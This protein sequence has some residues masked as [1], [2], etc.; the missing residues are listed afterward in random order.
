MVIVTCV[1][2]ED[3]FGDISDFDFN[4]TVSHID[5]DYVTD[6]DIV[7]GF[8]SFA[9]DGNSAC[10][11]RLVGDSPAFYEASDF[12]ELVNSQKESPLYL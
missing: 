8:D 7:G 6:F 11:A 9:V 5:F 2:F 10:I 4:G 1:F 3:V 12:E